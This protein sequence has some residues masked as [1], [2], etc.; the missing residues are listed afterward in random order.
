MT[1]EERDRLYDV[2]FDGTQE[3][4]PERP[5]RTSSI[6]LG[7]KDAPRKYNKTGKH[8]DNPEFWTK[9]QVEDPKNG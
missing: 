9:T 2:V 7:S 1:T 8:T 5:T 3:L 4:L 6:W